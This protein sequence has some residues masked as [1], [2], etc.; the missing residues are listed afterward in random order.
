MRDACENITLPQLRTVIIELVFLLQNH[1]LALPFRLGNSGSATCQKSYAD[2][3]S[4]ELLIFTFYTNQY[5]TCHG[6]VN[7]QGESPIKSQFSA[8][9]FDLI[10]SP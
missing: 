10:F 2:G 8:F 6:T 5:Q 7:I 1:G 4:V 9:W 3:A